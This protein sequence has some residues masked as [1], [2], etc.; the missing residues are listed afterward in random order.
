MEKKTPFLWVDIGVIE[1]TNNIAVIKG[2]MIMVK[3]NL[4]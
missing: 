3:L 4:S 1:N 2:I